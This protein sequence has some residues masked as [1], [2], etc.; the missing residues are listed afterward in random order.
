M[1]NGLAIAIQAAMLS[2]L[3][4]VV[5]IGFTLIFGVGGVLNLAHGAT[6]TIGAFAG[7]Y[8]VSAFDGGVFVAVTAAV[9]VSGAFGGVLY[10]GL[11]RPF[12]DDPTIIMILTLIV[13]IAIEYLFLVVEG[14]SAYTV[15]QLVAGTTTVMGASVPYNLVA[16]FVASW[17]IIGAVFYWVNRTD[18]GRAIIATSMDSKGAFLVGIDSDRINLLMWVVASILAGI[19]GYFFGSYLTIG[20]SM[21]RTPL[22]LSFAIVILGGLGS[23]RGSVIGAYLIG[24]IE[25]VTTNVINP[26]L[27]GLAPLVAVIVILLVRPSGLYGKEID[28]G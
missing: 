16:I 19:A 15:P 12:R 20:W 2:A 21:G 5:S 6:I 24:S 27:Q 10:L 17:L 8:A 18:T 7:F 1:V 23:V 4:A 22:I 3:Y 25:V 14:T 13:A 9:L 26:Q 28:I 11:I